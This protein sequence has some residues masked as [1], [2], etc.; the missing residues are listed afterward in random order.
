LNEA[1]RID[2]YNGWAYGE[3]AVVTSNWLW[4]T[5]ATSKNLELAMKLTP[6]DE[7]VYI[8][9]F[10]HHFRLGNCDKLDWALER[11]RQITAWAKSPY[12][13]HSLNILSCR[14]DYQKLASIA[15]ELRIPEDINTNQAMALFDA[16]L[17]ENRLEKA[18]QILD[19]IESNVKMKSFFYVRKALLS[20][21]KQN[22]NST[23]AMLD[24]LELF[25]EHEIVPR[26]YF[27]AIKASTGDREAMY[28]YLNQALENHERDIHDI[29]N[30]SQFNQY[31]EE[32]R[33]KE[34][35][36]KLWMPFKISSE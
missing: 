14:N 12:V 24:S 33:F 26:T 27:A 2:P 10:Y 16:C 15:D 35:M 13:Q 19:F 1:I 3:L 36:A 34:I 22:L 18:Q 25:S 30:F 21:A 23:N 17:N 31:K 5:I 29:N 11:L 7:N 32:P 8:H 9:Y 6:S 20:A 4:D 28:K